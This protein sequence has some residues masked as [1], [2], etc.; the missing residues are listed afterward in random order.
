MADYVPQAFRR[1]GTSVSRGAELVDNVAQATLV[2]FRATLL[3]PWF[4][5]RRGAESR[6]R[7][8]V[9][10]GFGVVASSAARSGTA[11]PSLPVYM[12]RITAPILSTHAWSS[13]AMSLHSAPAARSVCLTRT[14]TPA[15]SCST[16]LPSSQL[17]SAAALPVMRR[18]PGV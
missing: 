15:N 1:F 8:A 18:A 2:Q 9:Q 5:F 4:R 14:Y 13:A 12:E 17:T 7:G 3:R 10:G 11:V 16:A 6:L